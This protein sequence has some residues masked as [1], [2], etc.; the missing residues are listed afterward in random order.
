V[1]FQLSDLH[2]KEDATHPVQTALSLACLENFNAA[3]ASMNN[4]ISAGDQRAT[5]PLGEAPFWR[6]RTPKPCVY[7][8]STLCL[9]FPRFASCWLSY[10][11]NIAL[12]VTTPSSTGK[13]L[14]QNS[15][16]APR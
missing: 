9:A 11:L 10:C 8:A 2:L 4:A 12:R 14:N 7:S 16:R 1:L 3:L 5:L 15:L 13:R 6:I